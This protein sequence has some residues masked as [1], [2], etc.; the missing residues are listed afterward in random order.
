MN[1]TNVLSGDVLVTNQELDEIERQIDAHI[2]SLELLSYPRE[3]ALVH[4]LRFYEDY[5]RIYINK[6]EDEGA[7][8]RS[9]LGA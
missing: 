3:I 1:A 8:Q 6:G 2:P 7:Q 5:N 9:L 4:L